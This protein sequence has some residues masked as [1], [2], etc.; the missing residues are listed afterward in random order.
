MNT[1][2]PATDLVILAGG[3]AR[4]MNGMNKLLQQFDDQIQLSKICQRFKPEVQQLWVNSH[5]DSS[6]YKRIEPN[7]Q[8]YADDQTGFL[9]PLMGMKSAWSHVQS[10]YVLFVPCD[11]TYIPAQVLSRLH[12]T[13]QKN[14]QASAVYVT[15]NGDA[16][17]PFC[18]L[19]RA[20]LAVLEQQIAANRLSLRDCFKQLHAQTVAFQKQSLFC[21]SINSMDE[22]QQYQQMKA[23][24]QIFISN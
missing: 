18:L 6:I 3:Q 16:L 23:F 4:R 14:P 19:K 21:H 10:D 9:G 7:I 24:R 22:L 13:L 5:R 2:F 1:E 15:I 17:Y 8:C 20:S 11:V 12:R